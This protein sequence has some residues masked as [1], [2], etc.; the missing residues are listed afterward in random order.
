M[1][2][3]KALSRAMKKCSTREIA[4]ADMQAALK[5]WEVSS[6]DIIRILDRLESD[7][8]IDDRRFATAYIRDKMRFSGWGRGKIVNALRVKGISSSTINELCEELIDTDTMRDKID[9]EL[10]KKALTIKYKDKYDFRDKLMRFAASRGYDL[11]QSLRCVK[12]ITN[13]TDED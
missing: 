11:E 1:E 8:F 3:G 4:R 7:K 12:S 13:A 5:R 10:R 9:S 2:Y 6:E